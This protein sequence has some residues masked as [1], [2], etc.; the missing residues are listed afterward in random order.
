V[1]LDNY[2]TWTN[3]KL[4]CLLFQPHVVTLSD[5]L[6]RTNESPLNTKGLTEAP[7]STPQP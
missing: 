7:H 2:A 4:I 1:H 3:P 5:A 6:T